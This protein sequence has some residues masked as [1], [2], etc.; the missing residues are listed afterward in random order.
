MK[1]VLNCEICLN[2]WA[3]VQSGKQYPILP[4][5][6]NHIATVE[7]SFKV[8]TNSL[9]DLK[10]WYVIN[11]DQNCAIDFAQQYMRVLWVPGEFLSGLLDSLKMDNY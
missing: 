2:W 6:L 5:N 8:M 1:I 11:K 9:K 10:V 4:G 7:L 3:T